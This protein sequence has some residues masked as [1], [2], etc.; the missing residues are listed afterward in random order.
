MTE[1]KLIRIEFIKR[2]VSEKKR[3]SLTFHEF[4]DIYVNL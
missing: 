1:F 4:T 3:T 2:N